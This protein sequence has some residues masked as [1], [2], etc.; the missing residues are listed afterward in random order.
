MTDI[1]VH[2]VMN[3]SALLPSSSLEGHTY[4]H[5]YIHTGTLQD[6]LWHICR[7]NDKTYMWPY[8]V[9]TRAE[10]TFVVWVGVRGGEG[11]GRR[12]RSQGRVWG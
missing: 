7:G 4:I 6:S 12:R 11:G 1:H 5:I 9:G 8:V 10:L 2:M 3:S